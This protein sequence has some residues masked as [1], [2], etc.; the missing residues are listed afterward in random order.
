MLVIVK[1]P[2]S[3]GT[4]GYIHPDPDKVVE[5]KEAR[6]LEYAAIGAVWILPAELQTSNKNNISLQQTIK[7]CELETENEKL[8]AEIKILIA[9][10]TSKK[11]TKN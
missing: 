3:N 6:A 1:N 11:V 8:K 5:M 4:G 7:M 2:I 9:A 10:K